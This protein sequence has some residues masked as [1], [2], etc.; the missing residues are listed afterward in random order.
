VGP[1]KTLTTYMWA[2]Q[3]LGQWWTYIQDPSIERPPYFPLFIRPTL[4]N[5]THSALEG[6]FLNALNQYGLQHTDI[7]LLVIIDGYDELQ[8]DVEDPANLPKYLG[9]SDYLNSKLIVTCRP[10]TIDDKELDERFS[11]NGELQTYY[12]LPFIGKGNVD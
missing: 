11:L 8:M 6:A 5:W 9:I 10:N 12:F 1:G 3:L 7:P 2:D 4:S